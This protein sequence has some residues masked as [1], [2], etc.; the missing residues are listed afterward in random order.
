MNSLAPGL[1]MLAAL[2]LA[3]GSI[4]LWRAGADRKRAI[5]MMVAAAVF[6]INVLILTL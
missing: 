4:Y 5:L 3:A 1:L 2:A 6:L